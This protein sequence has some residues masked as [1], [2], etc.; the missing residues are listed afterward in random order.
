MTVLTSV[1]G[2]GEEAGLQA[3]LGRRQVGLDG[4]RR[5]VSGQLCICRAGGG[6]LGTVSAPLA[7]RL[8]GCGG[9]V[10]GAAA[11]ERRQRAWARPS[12]HGRRD[13]RL[14]GPQAASNGRPTPATARQSARNSDGSNSAVVTRLHA[15]PPQ[16][17]MECFNQVGCPLREHDH[18]RIRPGADR[19]S[20][21]RKIHHA[22]SLGAVH[23]AMRRRRPPV[24]PPAD[25]SDTCRTHGR[26]FRGAAVS[27]RLTARRAER[28]VRQ[29]RRRDAVLRAAFANLSP[30]R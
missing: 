5:D 30:R 8:R 11:G 12:A 21:D 14:A 23:A 10:V 16:V 2:I 22:Q 24:A 28:R 19:P 25:P 18:R 29:L 17:E 1:F 3:C 6:L 20:D 26:P 9:A 4:G 13:G 27:T 7:R 15:G